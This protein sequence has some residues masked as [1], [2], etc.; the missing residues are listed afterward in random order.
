MKTD[1]TVRHVTATFAH[2]QLML[3][4]VL[5]FNSPFIAYFRTHYKEAIKQFDFVFFGMVHITLM[6]IAVVVITIGS[7]VAK[8]QEHAPAKFRTMTIYYAIA[9]VIILAAIPWPFSPLSARPYF[10]TF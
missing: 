7:S 5:Y 3:G 2:I 9:F 1:N 8:R 10:R 6:T 4:Y